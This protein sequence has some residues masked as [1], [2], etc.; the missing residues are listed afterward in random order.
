MWLII[1]LLLV[2]IILLVVEL[3]FLPGI[4]IAGIGAFICLGAS[5]FFAYIQF[6]MLAGTLTL[7]AAIL[8]SILAVIVSLRANTWKRLSLN[9][10]VDG[11]STPLPTELN[12]SIGQ[13]GVTLTRLAPM[14]KVSFKGEIIEAKSI[15]RFIDPKQNVEVIGFDNT[16]AIVSLAHSGDSEQ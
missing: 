13:Q 10:T 3:L 9:T 8:L 15:D 16:V 6:G 5:V 1:S 2:G 11:V 12:I 14:G 7:T 4:S